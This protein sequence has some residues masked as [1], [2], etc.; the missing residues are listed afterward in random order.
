[1]KTKKIVSLLVC[2]IFLSSLTLGQAI[3][4]SEESIIDEIDFSLEENVSPLRLTFKKIDAWT[5]INQEI[6]TKKELDLA[7]LR[8]IQARNFAGE[9]NSVAMEKALEAHERIIERVENRIENIRENEE[10]IE[11]LVGLEKAVYV[12]RLRIERTNQKLSEIEISEQQRERWEKSVDKAE[13]V[14]ER[15]EKIQEQNKERVMNRVMENQGKT[16]E[17]VE[18][19][20]S[21]IEIAQGVQKLRETGK[22]IEA[23]KQQ[24]REAVRISGTVGRAIRNLQ[25]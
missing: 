6:K 22:E 19:I 12:H 20:I 11:K 14:I 24:E 7:R 23:I 1:M 13:E 8:L 25:N 9:N 3:K 10:D 17:E 5:A 18:E 4:S 2:L 16:I 15:I 21:D